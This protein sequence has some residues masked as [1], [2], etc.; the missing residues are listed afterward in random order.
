MLTLVQHP[1]TTWMFI[2][3]SADELILG[4]DALQAHNASV[5][6]RQN[7]LRLG[8]E[9]ATWCHGRMAGRTSGDGR[10]P[11]RDGFQGR[12]SSWSMYD[13]NASSTP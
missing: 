4:L 8:D 7:V 5:D 13:K 12:P 1:M 9:A 6:L 3:N 10:W 2:A 11:H